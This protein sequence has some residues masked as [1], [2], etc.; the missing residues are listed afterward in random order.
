M[1]AL[2]KMADETRGF[3][4]GDVLSLD[5]LRVA[6]C[7]AEL[8]S[9]FQ[10]LE[11]DL[12]VE[13]DRLELHPALE[14]PGVVAPLTK[15]ALI[16][17]LRPGSGL[18]IKLGPIPAQLHQSFH[19]CPEEGSQSGRIMANAALDVAVGG[20]FPALIKGLHVVAG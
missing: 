20:G 5:D 19:L 9:S 6:A 4:D 12:V 15:A 17:D 8:L 3:G 14:K 2:L 11:M 7:A 16:R 13:N 1:F 10:I 18:K